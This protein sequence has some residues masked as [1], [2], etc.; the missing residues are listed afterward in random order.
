MDK[1]SGKIE[2]SVVVP[3]YNEASNIPEFLLRMRKVL[4]SIAGNYEIIFATDPSTDRTEELIADEYAKDPRIKMLLFSRRVGQPMATLAGMKHSGGAAVV[5]IDVDLQDPPELIPEMVKKWH[6]G[7]DVVYAQRTSRKGETL[8]K[9]IVSYLGYKLINH[10]AEVEIPQNTGDFRLMSRRVVDEVTKLKE[11]HGFLRGM[12]ALVGF[13]Q[14]AVQF[15]RPARFAGTGNY[16]RFLGSLKIGING[17]VCF[18]HQLLTLSSKLGF[19]TAGMSFLA[20]LGCAILK[21]SGFPLPL[22]FASM[23]A[24]ILFMGGVQL[25]SI[26]ILGEYIARIYDEVKERPKYIVARELG[27]KGRDRNGGT[28]AT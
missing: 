2:L 18:S 6:A 1:N 17:M 21:L 25:I 24:V 16:N 9:R 11:S 10:I 7:F 27:F 28:N 26:G 3:V 8:I 20:V 15:E 12:V 14:T 23:L 4:E 22:G 13:K 5:V 19:F